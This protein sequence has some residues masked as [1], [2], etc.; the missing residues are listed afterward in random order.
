[1]NGLDVERL[2]VKVFGSRVQPM[3]DPKF[4]EEVKSLLT[5]Y[6]DLFIDSCPR[7][8]RDFVDEWAGR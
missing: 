7:Q 3:H 4:D 8:A 2:R 5:A 6:R 1:M